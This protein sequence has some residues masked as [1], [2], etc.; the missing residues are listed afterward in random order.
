VAC[1]TLTTIPHFIQPQTAVNSA[2]VDTR[3]YPTPAPNPL[4]TG[5]RPYVGPTA[6][7]WA[8]KHN[9]RSNTRNSPERT[10][11]HGRFLQAVETDKIWENNQ[12][13]WKTERLCHRLGILKKLTINTVAANQFFLCIFFFPFR[14]LM[15][16]LTFCMLF[17]VSYVNFVP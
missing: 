13:P 8:T 3:A 7:P 16:F 6:D 5:W 9:S 11:T 1:W 17:F 15:Y 14:M 10:R 2:T 12:T 4:K